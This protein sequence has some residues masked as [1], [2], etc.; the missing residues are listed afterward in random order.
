MSVGVFNTGTIDPLEPVFVTEGEF[1]AIVLEQA[2]FRAV[3]LPNAS[4]KLT[5]EMKDLLMQA[6]LRILAGDT[7]QPGTECMSRLWNELGERTYWLKWPEGCKDANETFLKQCGGDVEKFK[8]LV[9]QL[10]DTAKSTPMP[11]V[12]SLPE[13]M[14]SNNRTNLA[15]HPQRLRFPWPQVDKMALLLPGSV[16]TISATNTKQG[17]SAFVENIT[18]HAARFHGEVVLS[19]QA[20]LSVDEYSALATA[21]ILKRDRNHLT[22]ADFKEAA[23][24][25]AGVQYY[26]GRNS[27]I[28]TVGPALDLI[29]AAI[30]RLGATVVVID[31]LHFLC[32][33]EQNEIQ[34]QANAMQ[35]IKNLAVKYACK[36]IVVSQPRKADSKTK[37]KSLHIPDIKGSET[38]TSDADAVFV[39]HR[40]FIK[41]IDPNNP[42]QDDYEP[43]TN[44]HLLAARSKGDGPT[45][46]KLFFVGKTASFC[47]MTNRENFGEN[48]GNVV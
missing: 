32:R 9:V 38:L 8:E 36:F 5:P 47:E 15:D 23:A 45:F 6:D 48:T 24:K 1:D 27:T 46:A 4:T 22:P 33:N 11:G 19:Y 7:D 37:G 31:H 34:A 2:G 43:E 44:V 30:Q 40:E 21:E 17:K 25:L 41:N 20:E 10:V 13:S 39:I 42:P 18:M 28:T 12:Y 35:R 29:E 26:V 3:S 16:V 14:A